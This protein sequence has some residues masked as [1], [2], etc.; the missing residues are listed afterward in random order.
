MDCSQPAYFIVF[1]IATIIFLLAAPMMAVVR[2]YAG[3]AG[4]MQLNFILLCV[5]AG[6]KVERVV[7]N[8][9]RASWGQAAPP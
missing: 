6:R 3:L 5:V 1:A 7:P 2:G 8:A 4:L 9:P